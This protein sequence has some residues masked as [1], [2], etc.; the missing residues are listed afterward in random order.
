[1]SS[2]F[3]VAGSLI[4]TFAFLAVGISFFGPYWLSNAPSALQNELNF[5]GQGAYINC[6]TGESN[7][8]TD[9]T[10]CVGLHPDRGLWAQCGI[11][12]AWFWRNNY[13]LQKNLLTPLKW[14]LATQI[15]Y[16]IAAAM[17]LFCEIYARVQMC[18][19]PRKS[20]YL[21]LSITL[22]ASALIQVAA[23]AVFG[24]GA[25]RWPIY[26]ISDPKVFT[27]Y[28]GQNIL[29]ANPALAT[30]YLG[31]CYWMAVVGAMLTII[32]ALMFL[33]AVCFCKRKS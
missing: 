30:P 15:L 27:Q 14:H 9:G 10:L 17:I 24:G 31:W 5:T 23:V 22:F 21:S 28:L 18:C 33:F 29:G 12:C 20:I 25:S 32:S 7:V 26:A 8:D 11:D 2:G 1:M 6:N 3:F 4:Q 16:F 13:L 19:S